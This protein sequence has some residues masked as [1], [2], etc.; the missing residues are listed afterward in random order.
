MIRAKRNLLFGL[1][2]SEDRKQLKKYAANLMQN[3]SVQRS[4]L[5]TNAQ[6]T[7]IIQIHLAKN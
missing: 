4:F 1:T 5:G 3:Q 2:K 6:A 7:N